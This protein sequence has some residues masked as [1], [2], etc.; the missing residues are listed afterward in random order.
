[1]PRTLG[2]DEFLRAQEKEENPSSRTDA[3]SRPSGFV[4]AFTNDGRVVKLPVAIAD[5]FSSSIAP[6]NDGDP[7]IEYLQSQYKMDSKTATSTAKSLL[8]AE[9]QSKLHPNDELILHHARANSLQSEAL[10]AYA[11]K[12]IAKIQEIGPR[13]VENAQRARVH[14]DPVT[15]QRVGLAAAESWPAPTDPTTAR[16]PSE[17]EFLGG[18]SQAVSVNESPEGWGALAPGYL[19]Y[20]SVPPGALHQSQPRRLTNYIASI[21]AAPKDP[22]E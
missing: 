22:I 10:A 2:S 15:Q 21:N 19:G 6:S 11:Q 7:L 20:G 12:Q 8:D 16:I 9:S 17:G 4:H 13:A 18:P 3:L 5:R 14:V 1:M